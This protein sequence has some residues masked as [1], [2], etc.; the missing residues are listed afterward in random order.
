MAN[1]QNRVN[2]LQRN[3]RSAISNRTTLDQILSEKSINVALISETLYKPNHSVSF[4]Y[5]NI[6]RGDR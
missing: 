5:H 3:A 4:K 2:I 1:L 6:I